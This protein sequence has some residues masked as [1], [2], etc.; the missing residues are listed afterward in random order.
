VLIPVRLPD[1]ARNPVSI[2]GMAIA[3]AAAVVFLALFALEVAGYLTNPYIGLLVFV[4]VPAVFLAGLALIPIGAWWAARRRRRGLTAPDWPVIDLRDSRQRGIVAG[5]IALTM[6]NVAI[7]SMGAY[8]GVHYLESEAF[9]GRVCHV[10]EPQAVAHKVWPH[11][12]VACAQCHVG[13]GAGAYVE[14]KLAG[15]RQLFHVLTDR[16][17]L[18]VPAP[19]RLI[20]PTAVACAQCHSLP[21]QAGDALRVLRE[22]ASDETN[23][24]MQTTLRLH[25]GNRT[26]GIHRHVSMDIE[27]VAPDDPTATIPVVRLRTAGRVREYV[28]E[29]ASSDAPGTVRKMECIDCHNRPAHSFAATPARAIDAAIERGAIPRD[30]PFARREA[31][32][33]VTGSHPSRDAAM[34]SIAGALTAFYAARPGTDEALVRRAISGTQAVWSRNVFPAMKVTWGTYPNHLGHVD[35]QGCFRC[36]DDRK[37]ADGAT[38]AQECELCHSLGE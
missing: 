12:N 9:C 10:M 24:E 8:G 26:S 33:A 14:G 23:T 34:T 28:A 4:T 27:Y 22:Y 2:L 36:H 18:P 38:I 25:V 11:A 31:L 13:P 5:V 16:V 29:G 19:D 20:Q 21:G 3:S 35:T 32:A 15:T 7:V 1:A 6:V 37:A 17:P 30:L